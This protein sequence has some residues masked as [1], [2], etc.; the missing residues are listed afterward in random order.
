MKTLVSILCLTAAWQVGPLYAQLAPVNEVGLSLGHLHLAA[1]DREKEAKAWIALGGQLENNLSG[2]IPIGF[3]GVV[4]LV[5]QSR[6]VSGGSAGSLI[7]HVAFRVPNLQASLA[8]WKGLETWWKKG[9]WGLT[10]EPGTKPGQAFVTTPA[11]TKCEILEDNTLKAPIVFDHV[12]YVVQESRKSEM[13]DYYAKMFGAK[14]VKGEPDTLSV[15]GSKLVF[16]K[17]ATATAETMGRSLDHIG[18]NMLNADVLKAF[19]ATLEGKGAKF[20]RPYQASS[21]GMIRIVDGFGTLIEITKAQGGY[22][23]L[24]LLDPAYYEFDEGGRRQGE[25]PTRER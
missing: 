17:S 5:G 19:A 14:P 21:M 13:Q 10:L 20:Q 23:D 12:H 4:V 24:K 1:P 8:K 25:T 15:P 22:F 11:G 16:T 2:N 3:P 9:N 7:D 6:P 18:F